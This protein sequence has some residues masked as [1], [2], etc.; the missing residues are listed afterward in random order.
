M[1]NSLPIGNVVVNIDFEVIPGM[2]EE[3]LK[4]VYYLIDD[5]LKE[6]GNISYRVFKE[7]RSTDRYVVIEHWENQ[8]ALNEHLSMPHTNYYNDNVSKY[9][10]IPPNRVELVR[11]INSIE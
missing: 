3:F 6:K 8:K 4:L 2:E 11:D 9:L 5:S 7:E 10:V 1:A